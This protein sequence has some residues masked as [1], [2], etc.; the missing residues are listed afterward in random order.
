MMLLAQ[1][2]M[3]A[4]SIHVLR[5]PADGRGGAWYRAAFRGGLATP[6]WTFGVTDLRRFPEARR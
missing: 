4:Q 1:S 2:F 3:P 6:E 5:N